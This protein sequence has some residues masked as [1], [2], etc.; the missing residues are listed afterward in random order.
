MSAHPES[1]E[2]KLYLSMEL[3]TAAVNL[4]HTADVLE[5][6]ELKQNFQMLAITYLTRADNLA[7]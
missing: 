4:A 1:R 3:A 2:N 6:E 7:R 5:S